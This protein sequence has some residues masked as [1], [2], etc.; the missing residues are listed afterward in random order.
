[1]TSA[2]Q[3]GG[4]LSLGLR[5]QIGHGLGVVSANI[6]TFTVIF[7]PMGVVFTHG[8][9][10]MA[11]IGGSGDL[12]IQIAAEDAYD[13]FFPRSISKITRPSN[14]AACYTSARHRIDIFAHAELTREV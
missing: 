3:L 2:P 5:T 8:V 14:V 9:M 7:T 13:T 11:Q 6:G 4:D 12:P 1:M 10:A